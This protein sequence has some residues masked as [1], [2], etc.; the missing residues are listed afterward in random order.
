M[1]SVLFISTERIEID[2]DEIGGSD[3]NERVW[4]FVKI[5]DLTKPIANI[6]CDSGPDENPPLPKTF[7]VSIQ[8]LRNIASM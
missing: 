2:G 6:L 3:G 7:N 5:I 4:K 8:V 1:I